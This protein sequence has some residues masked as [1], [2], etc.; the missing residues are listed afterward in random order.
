MMDVFDVLNDPDFASAR[1]VIRLTWAVDPMGYNQAAE[2][3]FDVLAAVQ[4][5]S[6]KEIE[7]LPEAERSRSTIAVWTMVE[8]DQ[9]CK[10]EWRDDSYRIASVNVWDAFG[11]RLFHALAIKEDI[12]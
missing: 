1:S 2:E 12:S 8:L 11:G 4:P 3:S 10:M 6:P 5:A 9:G 7:T